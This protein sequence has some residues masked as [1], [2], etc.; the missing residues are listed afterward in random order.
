M[1]VH[2]PNEAE[3]AAAVCGSMALVAAALAAVCA[4]HR[5]RGPV[6]VV[7]WAARVCGIPCGDGTSGST[8]ALTS[9]KVPKN[10]MVQVSADVSGMAPCQGL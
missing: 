7:A 9:L 6:P 5:L 3:I 1:P 4:W 10:A 2:H 8:D